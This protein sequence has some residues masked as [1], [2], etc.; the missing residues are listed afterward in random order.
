[1]VHYLDFIII[2]LHK[3]LEKLGNVAALFIKEGK[4]ETR[5]LKSKIRNDFRTNI[6]NNL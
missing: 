6:F 2:I 5:H 4:G 1:M 3:H